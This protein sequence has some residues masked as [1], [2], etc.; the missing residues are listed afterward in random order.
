MRTDIELDMQTDKRQND[1][2]ASIGLEAVTRFVLPCLCVST[3]HAA[4]IFQHN[5]CN[6]ALHANFVDILL[7]F[8]VLYTNRV[9]YIYIYKLYFPF[10]LCR[11]LPTK[12]VIFATP[13]CWRRK[14]SSPMGRACIWVVSLKYQK[15]WRTSKLPGIITQRIRDGKTPVFFL[16]FLHFFSA[17][18]M[19]KK[20]FSVVNHYSRFLHTHFWLFLFFFFF[21]FLTATK[22]S[23]VP[24]SIL[25]PLSAVWLSY[26]WMK[27]MAVAT[28][29]IWA[30][31]YCAA[32]TSP[33]M[34]TGE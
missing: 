15:C 30:A 5:T 9:I 12:P 22:S 19:L 24:P 14:S 16:F 17:F 26:R 6:A 18:T 11:M 2:Q 34:H 31:P 29:A 28:I 20:Q 32:T 4:A 27:R 13:A 3:L 25:R 8:P 10:A 7:W 21:C 23:T 33:S 1:R